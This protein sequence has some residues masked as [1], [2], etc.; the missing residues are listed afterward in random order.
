[1]ALVVPAEAGNHNHR[2]KL[3]LRAGYYL[4]FNNGGAAYGS[5]RPCA[6]AHSAGTTLI[7][8][9]SPSRGAMRPSTAPHR[10]FNPRQTDP[11][12]LDRDPHIHKSGYMESEQAILALAALAQPTR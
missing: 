3:L 2:R 10:A 1:M 12:R 8:M 11:A 5:R 4:P 7:D 6:I 9:R